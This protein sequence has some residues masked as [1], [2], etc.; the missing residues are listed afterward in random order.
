MK[1]EILL[2]TCDKVS[3]TGQLSFVFISKIKGAYQEHEHC[4]SQWGHIWADSGNA[5]VLLFNLFRD[6]NSAQRGAFGQSMDDLIIS[7]LPEKCC[8]LCS[9]EE[10]NTLEKILGD[11]VKIIRLYSETALQTS[12]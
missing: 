5:N 10:A 8:M 3:R 12:Y 7:E 11:K 4:R 9:V 2:F 6:G 1:K